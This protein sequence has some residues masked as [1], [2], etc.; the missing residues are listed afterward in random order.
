M[1]P[2]VLWVVLMTAGISLGQ[3]PVDSSSNL[4]LI[5]AEFSLADGPAWDGGWAMYIPDVKGQKLHRYVPKTRTMQVLMPNAGRI[6][7][8]FF[9]HGRLY[10]SDNGNSRI[11][12]LQGKKLVAVFEHEKD[13]KQAIRPNDLVVDKHGGIYYTLS[14]QGQVNYIAPGVQD[15]KIVVEGIKTPNGIILS[16]DGKTLYISSFAPKK[17]WA[18]P[19][20][21]EAG[22]N[23]PKG[24]SVIVGEGRE[25]AAMDD[26]D[27]KGADGMA[28]DRA[29][30]V[31]CAGAQ[32]VWIWNPSGKLIGKIETPTRPINCT[33]GDPDMRSL[34]IA[35]FGGLYKQRMIISGRAPHP[36]DQKD[37]RKSRANRPSTEIPK[38]IEAHLDVVYAQYGDRKLLADIFVPR[39]KP[40]PLPTIVVVHGGGWLN[41]DKTKFRALALGLAAKGYV[42]AAIEYRLAGEAKF[43]AGIQDCN[44]AV[45]FLRANGKAFKVDPKRIGAVGGS[46]GGHL[47]GLMATGFALKELQG[48]GGHAYQSSKLQAAVV[49]AGPMQMTTGWVAERSRNQPNKSNAYKWLGKSIDHAPDLYKLAAPYQHITWESPP[50]LFLV[51]EL[52]KPQRNQPMRDKLKSIGVWTDLMFYKDGKHGCW[53]RLPWFTDMVRDMDAFFKVQLK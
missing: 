39:D 44:A 46:A 47:V 29:G 25:F 38:N 37:E 5:S 52:D 28:M 4:E 26:G 31:Y 19:I 9:S 10:V 20:K 41:G 33:F 30:N 36:T 18:Y 24:A 11:A 12:R 45:R 43:P 16:P 15:S 27:A 6:S 34:Y 50:I 17:I 40:G 53:N 35:C 14:R 8:S 42:T 23:G 1:T 22:P 21:D 49:M 51:G 7:A 48:P 2:A 3:S 32:H 13:A